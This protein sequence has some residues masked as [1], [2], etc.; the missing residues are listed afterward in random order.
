MDLVLTGQA[1]HVLLALL[2]ATFALLQRLALRSFNNYYLDSNTNK[3]VA[4]TDPNCDT[5]YYGISTGSL[6]Y[7]KT[8][9]GGLLLQ[10][11]IC[12]MLKLLCCN[13]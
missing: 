3:C 12:H 8:C 7:C 11:S 2:D 13:H 5:V 4:A 10:F 9:T 1:L 6:S